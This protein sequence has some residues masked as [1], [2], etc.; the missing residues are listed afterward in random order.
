MIIWDEVSENT[1]PGETAF[2]AQEVTGPLPLG[3][4]EPPN[5]KSRSVRQ[6]SSLSDFGRVPTHGAF[7]KTTN[8]PNSNKNLDENVRWSALARYLGFACD[9][10]VGVTVGVDL[11]FVGVCIPPNT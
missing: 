7:Q 2:T 3:Y 9:R 1:M 6:L 5:S 10:A 8:I 4:L 11:G